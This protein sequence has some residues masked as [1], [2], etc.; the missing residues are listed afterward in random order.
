VLFLDGTERFYHGVGTGIPKLTTA[1]RTILRRLELRL[2]QATPAPSAASPAVILSGKTKQPLVRGKP[3]PVLRLTQ[4]NV[5]KALLDVGESG[6]TV[7]QLVHHSGHT[8]ARGIL[9]RLADS[10]PA[11]R[12]VIHFPGKTGGRYRIG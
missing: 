4:F 2:E 12:A 10:D 8:D 9:R 6:L 1:L 7:D 3:K 11:W 5:V